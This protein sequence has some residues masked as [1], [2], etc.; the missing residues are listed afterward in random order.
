MPNRDS[1]FRKPLQSDEPAFPLP[2][3]L[4]KINDPKLAPTEAAPS[5]QSTPLKPSRLNFR[6]GLDNHIKCDLPIESREIS[7]YHRNRYNLRFQSVSRVPL[8]DLQKILLC[9][10]RMGTLTPRQTP[11]R[12]EQDGACYY[13]KQRF[14]HSVNRSPSSA[15]QTSGAW[16]IP[17]SLAARSESSKAPLCW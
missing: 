1:S 4:A 13:Y 10:C 15:K 12:R 11:T 6:V 2:V 3:L 7:V 14:T 8:E 17:A 5:A 9:A 16:L